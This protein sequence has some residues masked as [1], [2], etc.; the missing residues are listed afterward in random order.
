VEQSNIRVYAS[1]VV[2]ES[3]NYPYDAVGSDYDS[4]GIFQQRA[5]Y[6]PDI[7][8]DMDPARSAA[9]FFSGMTSISGWETMDVGEL[10]QAVQKSAY[11][12]RYNEHLSEAEDICSA[13]GV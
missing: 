10:C 5:E 6:Y 9:Q 12:D 4:I 7:A 11:P 3:F 8:A 13:G 2:P 1:D